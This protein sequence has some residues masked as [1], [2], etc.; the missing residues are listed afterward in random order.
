[1]N[2]RDIEQFCGFPLSDSHVRAIENPSD[3]IHKSVEI[4][5]PEGNESIS[6]FKV[7]M[8]MRELEWKEW[9]SDHIAFA[10]HGCGDYFIF[11]RTRKNKIYYI[12]PIG[13]V[14]ESIAGCEDEGFFFED[15]ES[16]YQ[17]ELNDNQ[18][19]DDNS[20]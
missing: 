1:M 12:D 4:L 2:T 20:E 15:F 5:I 10:T 8:A 7:N 3:P 13:T 14:E 17:N 19:G 18:S 9:T 6:F 16:W 11:D